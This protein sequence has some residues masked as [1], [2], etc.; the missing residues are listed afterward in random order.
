MNN[1]ALNNTVNSNV[2]STTTPLYMYSDKLSYGTTGIV[3]IFPYLDLTY[4]TQQL[5]NMT[6]LQ[7][8][9]IVNGNG[10]M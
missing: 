10:T 2:D 3:N 9:K 5:Y 8:A 7:I 6:M 4:T 1:T